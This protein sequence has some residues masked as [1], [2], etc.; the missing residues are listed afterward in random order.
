MYD[1]RNKRRAV[2]IRL[3]SCSSEPGVN[4]KSTCQ[5]L[6]ICSESLDYSDPT[7][8]STST[9]NFCSYSTITKSVH[10]I[11]P[12]WG[13]LECGVF[14]VILVHHILAKSVWGA[15]LV[16]A[17]VRVMEVNHWTGYDNCNWELQQGG[18][19][20]GHQWTLGWVVETRWCLSLVERMWPWQAVI[21]CTVRQ[22]A[23]P[24]NT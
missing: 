4:R 7:I 23:Q 3:S 5:P 8:F 14:E 11:R 17:M 10:L 19:Q 9:N 20:R 18:L 21:G 13:S 6:C 2:G 12:Q 24:T 16:D 22:L 1:S 15:S